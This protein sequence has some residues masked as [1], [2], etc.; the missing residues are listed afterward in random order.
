MSITLSVIAFTS[1]REYIFWVPGF[2]C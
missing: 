2:Q 1:S